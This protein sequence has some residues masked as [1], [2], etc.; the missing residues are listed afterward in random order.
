MDSG[1][2]QR[3]AQ[4]HSAELQR[5][6]DLHRLAAAAREARRPKTRTLEIPHP[7][8]GLFALL[9]RTGNAPRRARA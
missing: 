4:E 1:L 7:G 8:A 2:N 3:H 9:S 5:R 6:A